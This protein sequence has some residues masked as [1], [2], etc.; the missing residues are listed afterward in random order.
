MELTGPLQTYAPLLPALS[1]AMS[2]RAG[3]SSEKRYVLGVR[4]VGSINLL[5]KR[6]ALGVK[7]GVATV[8]DLPF[9][10]LPL[11]SPLAGGWDLIEAGGVYLLLLFHD[12]SAL[13]R[14]WLRLG[15]GLA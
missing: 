6:F 14:I 9:A 1:A 8:F 13:V 10:A 11:H 7:L 15:G 3:C 4:V 2:Y 12:L 5:R